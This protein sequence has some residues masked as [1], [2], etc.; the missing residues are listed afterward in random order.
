MAYQSGFKPGDLCINQLL[1]I[2]HQVC[3]SFDDH[4]E[5]QSVFSDILKAFDKEW[6]KGFIFKLKQNGISG[7]TLST[8]I[9][10][11]KIGKH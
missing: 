6:H 10:F 1:S 8:L 9:D 11:L 2:T 4:Q 3:K 5:V 7:N